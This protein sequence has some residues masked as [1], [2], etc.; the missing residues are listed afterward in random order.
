[1]SDMAAY[2]RALDN[3]DPPRTIH[4]TNNASRQ[5]QL[6]MERCV[7]CYTE[8]YLVNMIPI[9]D[10]TICRECYDR[11]KKNFSLIDQVKGAKI[12]GGG[13]FKTWKVVKIKA[14]ETVKKHIQVAN[15]VK[16]GPMP[17]DS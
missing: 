5:R 17:E 2:L 16:Y 10:D 15:L 12:L 11:G 9:E 4:S 7:I 14:E 6:S 3:A 8:T 1:M 13:P